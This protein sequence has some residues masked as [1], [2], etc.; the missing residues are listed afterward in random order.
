MTDEKQY[1]PYRRYRV[2][3]DGHRITEMTLTPRQ[4]ATQ[5]GRDNIKRDLS[6]RYQVP[7]SYFRLTWIDAPQIKKG[8]KVMATKETKQK[9]KE[10]R[11]AV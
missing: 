2:S 9:L 7:W 8:R 10:M 4:Y 5:S 11:N 1:E 3:V 6:A